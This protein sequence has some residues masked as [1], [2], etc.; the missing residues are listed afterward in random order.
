MKI[1]LVYQAGI[2]NVFR[3]DAFSLSKF[4]GRTR[5]LQSDFRSCEAFA[6]G[7]EAAGAEV[8]SAGCN[9][10]GDITLQDW[11]NDLGPFRDRTLPINVTRLTE[12]IVS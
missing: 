5:M 9:M 10:A 1:Y 12:E 6:C 8:R 2:A 11:S 3:V 7:M 4:T